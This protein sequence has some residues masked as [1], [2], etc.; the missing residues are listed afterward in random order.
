MNNIKKLELESYD[1]IIS[2]NSKLIEHLQRDTSYIS[3]NAIES[4]FSSNRHD[5]KVYEE[6]ARIYYNEG[7]HDGLTSSFEKPLGDETGKLLF[8]LLNKI[9]IGFVYKTGPG[10]YGL[11]ARDLLLEDAYIS[12]IKKQ[13]VETVRFSEYREMLLKRIIKDIDTYM[14]ETGLRE[15]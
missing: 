7:F 8:E 9:A 1:G 14:I 2:N 13:K 4:F 3:Q 6:G 10:R 11:E 12:V 15:E 5:R